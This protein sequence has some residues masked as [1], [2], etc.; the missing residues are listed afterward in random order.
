MSWQ[1]V[2]MPDAIH[3]VPVDDLVAHEDRGCVCGPTVE[4]ADG[5]APLVTHH[6][7]DGRE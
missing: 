6:A 2:D 4:L 7:L 1:A 3:V 5:S